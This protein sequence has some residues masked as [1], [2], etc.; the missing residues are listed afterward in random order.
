MNYPV[1]AIARYTLLEAFKNRLTVFVA[2]GMVCIFALSQFA[3]ELAI[4]ETRQVQAGLAGFVLRLAAVFL[5]SL[6][7]VTSTLREFHDKTVDMIIALP[8]R[9]YVYFLGK[10]T[11][12]SVLGFM[13]AACTG[14]L[15]LF[16]ADTGRVLIWTISLV[17]ELWIVIALSL[18]FLFTLGNVTTACMAVAAFYLLARC[19][20]TIQLLGQSPIIEA[21]A[22]SQKFMNGV[23][24][25]IGYL[26]PGLHEFTRSEWLAHGAEG[27]SVLG[28][29]LL[30]TL[31]YIVLLSAAALFDFYRK[32]F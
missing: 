29:V 20:A 18:L 6:F 26:L 4:T 8:F 12:F 1:V 31:I 7:V 16:F 2:A 27:Y 30:Q 11:G 14:M 24:E 15:L 32:N 5:I 3:G 25:L 10:L 22:F 21:T 23:I 19:M 13:L 28:P 17:C 9:R